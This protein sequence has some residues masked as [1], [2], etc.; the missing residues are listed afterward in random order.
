MAF[1]DTASPDVY[2]ATTNLTEIPSGGDPLKYADSAKMN[3]LRT[4]VLALHGWARG[5]PVA[6]TANGHYLALASGIATAVAPAGGIRLRNNVGALEMS[7]SGE[8]YATISGSLVKTLV[9]ANANG[10]ATTAIL[11]TAAVMGRFVVTRVA[12]N[13]VTIAAVTTHPTISIGTLAGTDIDIIPATLL[14]FAASNEYRVLVPNVAAPLPKSAPAST[15]I[16]IAMSGGAG[17]S[18]AITVHVFGYYIGAV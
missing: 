14:N 15:S 18:Y 1:V 13:A 8:G 3:Q 12:I 10:T 5:V 11:T 16:R 17:T 6:E 9:I 2:A 4:G 7:Y